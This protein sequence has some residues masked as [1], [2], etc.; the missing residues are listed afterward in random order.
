M[1]DN[2][3]LNTIEGPTYPVASYAPGKS[4]S[5]EHDQRG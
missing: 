1:S 3:M 4:T 2:L 5:M